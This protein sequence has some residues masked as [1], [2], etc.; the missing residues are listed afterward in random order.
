MGPIKMEDKKTTIREGPNKF[1]KKTPT[2]PKRRK[3]EAQ[4]AWKQKKARVLWPNQRKQMLGPVCLSPKTLLQQPRKE[5]GLL[6]RWNISLILTPTQTNC[7]GQNE[8]PTFEPT[9]GIVIDLNPKS[10]LDLNFSTTTFHALFG[11][12]TSSSSNPNTQKVPPDINTLPTKTF[13]EFAR[14]STLNIQL[15]QSEMDPG[16]RDR[17]RPSSSSGMVDGRTEPEIQNQE[18]IP[19]RHGSVPNIS[20]ATQDLET[21]VG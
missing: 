7:P 19:G 4:E 1:Q 9:N 6:P 18:I 3:K 10:S 21:N 13:H 15:S 2:Q 11:E 16:N 20:E 8:K 14:N 5:K 17:S 12:D